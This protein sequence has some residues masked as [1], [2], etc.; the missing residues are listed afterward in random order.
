[1]ASGSNINNINQ[2]AYSNIQS[3]KVYGS[4]DNNENAKIESSE[5][6]KRKGSIFSNSD[7]TVLNEVINDSKRLSSDKKT[8]ANSVIKKYLGGISLTGFLNNFA[9]FAEIN[10]STVTI[11]DKENEADV[12]AQIG[13]VNQSLNKTEIIRQKVAAL[14]HNQN[15]V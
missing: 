13:T 6:K 5:A 9:G 7:E 1:M 3:K 8:L 12:K 14:V 2:Q 4:A 15:T 11:K 10:Y